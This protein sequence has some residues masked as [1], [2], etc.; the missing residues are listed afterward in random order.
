M[1]TPEVK[2]T[3]AVRLSPNV[4]NALEKSLPIPAVTQTTTELQAGFALGIQFVLKQLRDGFVV[5]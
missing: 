4:Y 3:E 2:I 5:K 1:A